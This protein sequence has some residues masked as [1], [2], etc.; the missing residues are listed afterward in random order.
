MNITNA[1][2]LLDEYNVLKVRKSITK[3]GGEKEWEDM[4]IFPGH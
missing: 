2:V 3:T 1:L 4:Q